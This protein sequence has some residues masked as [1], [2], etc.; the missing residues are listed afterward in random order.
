MTPLLAIFLVAALGYLAGR[1]QVRGVSLGVAAVLFAGLAVSALFPT[2]SIPEIVP[3]LGLVIFLYAIGIASG[4]G[5]FASF[6]RRGLRDAALTVALVLLGALLSA[7]AGH[8]IGASPE[9]TAGL[10]AGSLTNT[11]ALAAVVQVL[12]GTAGDASAPVVAYS[13]AYPL[14]VLGLL[15]AMVIGERIARR[16]VERPS[17]LGLDVEGLHLE[18][19]TVRI[20]PNAVGNTLANLREAHHLRIAFGRHKRGLALEVADDTKP[21][22]E[23]DLVS[24]IGDKA[25]CTKALAALGTESDEHVELDRNVLDFRRIAVTK[26]ELT[27]R[28]LRELHLA[29]R[30][31]ATITR[32][33][34]GD[35]ELLPTQETELEVGDRVR[36]IAPRRRM[37]EVSRFFGDSVRASAEVDTLTFGLGIVIGL[38]V[39]E[40]PVPLPG[41]SMF[42]LGVA[43]GPLVVALILG[44]IGRTGPLVWNLPFAASVTLRQ[45]GLLL[46]LGGVGLRS[47]HAFAETLGRGEGLGVLAMGALITFTI[48]LLTIVL[49]NRVFR[50]PIELVLGMVSGVHTQPAA[51]AFASERTQSELARVGYASVF[52]IAT[53]AKIVI[54]QLLL[55][56]LT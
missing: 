20:G 45:V 19:V 6:R 13:V 37:D 11:P 54:A 51:L 49:A 43:G 29:T 15:L 4:P 8:L 32:I 30:F 34:R 18:T 52:P 12:E 35:V 44:H 22:C 1:I 27:S 21:L 23:G 47:G 3:Q 5:F 24:L 26:V 28:P 33:R 50:L 46:F 2:L 53:V 14:G 36:V 41:G 38:L 25:S 10:F 9:T 40:V 17:L 7:L 56:W 48:A 42:R 16:D 55:A 31:G 39:G